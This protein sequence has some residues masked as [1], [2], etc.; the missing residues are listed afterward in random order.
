MYRLWQTFQFIFGWL[1]PIDDALAREYLTQAEFHLYMRM[2]RSERQHHLRVL[3]DLLSNGHTHSALLKAALLHDVG[4]TR[5]TFGLPQRIVVVVVKKL[6]PQRFQKWGSGDPAGWKRSFVI[7][8]QHPQWSAE[9]AAAVN[10]PALAVELIR[11]HQSPL[12]DAPQSEAD[13]LLLL[14]QAADN[15]S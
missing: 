6:M 11:R 1:K 9:M 2:S 4:K 3:Q 5:F 10:V 15:R 14:L 8:M 13:H 7:S 12:P